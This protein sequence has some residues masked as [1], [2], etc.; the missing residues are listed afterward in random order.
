[1]KHLNNNKKKNNSIVRGAT[2]AMLV[3]IIVVAGPATILE[4]IRPVDALRESFPEEIRNAPAIVSGD[5][6]YIANH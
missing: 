6:I 3:T 1:M 5:N 4:V 2:L